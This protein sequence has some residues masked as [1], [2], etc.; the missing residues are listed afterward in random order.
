M[1]ARAGQ[2]LLV[3]IAL[4]GI[5][6]GFRLAQLAPFGQAAR[7]QNQAGGVL[8]V[9][10]EQLL[11]LRLCLGKTA[12][13]E[14]RL[15]AFQQIAL[16]RCRGLYMGLE[17]G[18]NRG[19]RLRTGETVHRLAVLEQHHGRQAADTEAGDDLLLD[20]AVDLGQQQLALVLLGDLRQQGHQRLAWRAP[21]GP[22]IHQHRLVERVLEHQLFETGGGDIEDIGRLAH[23]N[24]RRRRVTGKLCMV[25]GGAACRKQ[26]LAR[27]MS[28]D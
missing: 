28:L 17:H 22:E 15:S 16:R 24:S 23:R 2:R 12:F 6:H 20:V 9:L 8:V 19:F 1:R 4:H 3:L 14:G 18:A 13:G 26:G 11:Q 27:R 25:S 21:F 10:A 5:E 7:V